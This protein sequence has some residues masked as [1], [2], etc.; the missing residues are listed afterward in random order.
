MY[1]TTSQENPASFVI[2]KGL[3]NREMSFPVA[4][5]NLLMNLASALPSPPISGL[6]APTLDRSLQLY[7]AT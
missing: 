2:D 4:S 1:P 5:E 3:K 6:P 7:E